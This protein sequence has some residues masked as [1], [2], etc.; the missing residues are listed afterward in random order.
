MQNQPI[1][2]MPSASRGVFR[3]LLKHLQ[4][5][6]ETSIYGVDFTDLTD[7]QVGLVLTVLCENEKN[8]AL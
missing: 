2:R 4:E 5:T 7:E 6:G 1:D 3:N 8:A